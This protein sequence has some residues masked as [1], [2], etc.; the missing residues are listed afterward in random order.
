MKTGLST[1]VLIC[2][3]FA[4]IRSAAGVADE[5][6]IVNARLQTRSATAGLEK[7]FRALTNQQVEPAWVGYTVPANPHQA[8]A[9]CFDWSNDG[10]P[11]S[12]LPRALCARKQHL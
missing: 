9:C 8:S 3:V 1:A 7:E 4:G 6:K 2:F 12:V 10:Q 5:P 11:L